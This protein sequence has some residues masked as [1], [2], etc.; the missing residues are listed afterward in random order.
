ML[1]YMVYV[2]TDNADVLVTFIQKSGSGK[3]SLIFKP[4]SAFNVKDSKSLKKNKRKN[5]NIF[6][7]TSSL[8]VSTNPKWNSTNETVVDTGQF[9]YPPPLPYQYSVCVSIL[10]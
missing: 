7:L 1:V 10:D 5:E 9:P 4:K 8:P 3:I 6:T 2:A